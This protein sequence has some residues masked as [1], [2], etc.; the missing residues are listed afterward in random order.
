MFAKLGCFFYLVRETMNRPKSGGTMRTRFARV[1]WGTYRISN[2]LAIGLPGLGDFAAAAPSCG[3]SHL[4]RERNLTRGT[5][6]V[7]VLPVPSRVVWFRFV[8]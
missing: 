4:D 3:A 6:N 2:I 7:E 8:R 1:T 5:D